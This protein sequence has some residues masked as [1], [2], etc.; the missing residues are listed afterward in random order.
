MIGYYAHHQGAGHLSRAAIVASH[1]AEPVTLLSSAISASGPFTEQVVLA[2]D[3][4][5]P[6]STQDPTAHGALHWVPLHDR[7][8]QRRM[9][10]IAT[11]IERSRP[12]ALVV[13]VSVEVATL[14]R[15]LGVPV[16]TVAMPGRRDDPAH[17]LGYR[18]SRLIIAPWPREVYDPPWLRPF[19]DRTHY[20]GAFSRYDDRSAPPARLPYRSGTVLCGAGGSSLNPGTLTALMDENPSITWDV[21]GGPAGWRHEIWP[22]L[23]AADVVVSHGGQNAV[24]EIAAARRPAVLVPESRPYDE[25]RDA[26]TALRRA[27][28]ARTCATWSE[29]SAELDAPA[30]DPA[31]WAR[32]SPPGAAAQAARLIDRVAAGDRADG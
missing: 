32:W 1:L 14:A 13:D 16:V 4:D 9:S 19:A 30:M 17:R 24:A 5:H 15:L 29:V 8:L 3:A 11:W 12:R 26:C 18:V 28:L 10:Q 20:V 31:R 7:G 2:S 22:A 27:G 6:D 25:Q 23:V 21:V